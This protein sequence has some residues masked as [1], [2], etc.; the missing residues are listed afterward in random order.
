MSGFRPPFLF[1]IRKP[2]LT[3]VRRNQLQV[4]SAM[5]KACLYLGSLLSVAM[6]LTGCSGGSTPTTPAN[7]PP[8]ANTSTFTPTPLLTSTVTSTPTTSFTTTPTSVF[9]RT[10]TPTY[11]ITPT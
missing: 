8:P 2:I 5:K 11:S 10:L 4:G 9:T 1:Q 6:V 3:H 7:N